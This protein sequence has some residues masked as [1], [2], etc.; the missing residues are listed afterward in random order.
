MET[1]ASSRVQFTT[2]RV[3]RVFGLLVALPLGLA[4]LSVLPSG[5]LPESAISVL[6]RPFILLV[7]LPVAIVGLL[8]FEPLRLSELLA[9]VPFVSEIAFLA[10]LLGFYYLLAV[11]LV[12]SV[13]FVRRATAE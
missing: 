1:D 3:V 8:V 2:R 10:G 9:P 11:L 6:E 13:A 4:V 7:Y 5:F 12:N